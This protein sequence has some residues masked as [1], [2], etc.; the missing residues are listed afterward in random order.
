MSDETIVLIED[1]AAFTGTIRPNFG[2]TGAILE[3]TSQEPRIEK[4]KSE[5]G[6]AN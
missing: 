4:E 3:S 1:A 6:P 5:H 2:A